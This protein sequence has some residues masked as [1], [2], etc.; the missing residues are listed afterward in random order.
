VEPSA[1]S[2]GQVIPFKLSGN[3]ST[4]LT[5][6][7]IGAHAD[8]I[9]IGCGG[10]M[11]QLLAAHR[12][13]RVVWVVLAAT[14]ERAT[15]ARLSARRFLRHPRAHQIIVQDFRDGFLPY[16]AGPV[17]E[18]FET[19]KR[20]SPDVIFTHHRDDRHQDHR[21]ASELTWNTFRDH[22]VLEYE[23]PKY[24]GGLGTPNVYVPLATAIQRRKIRLLMSVFASQR[25]KSWFT[26]TTFA[27]LM[28]L[29]G[30]EC[31]APDG[32]AEG[33]HGHKIVVSV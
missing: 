11:L 17:K 6:L 14:G 28:R 16:S 24:D 22:C 31:A 9:E 33:F 5:V 25:S 32:F 27:A 20:V 23:I 10:T 29:R 7:C 4:P 1:A 15:E 8:D 21:L 19:L 2:D 30:V 12:R 3:A 13:I 18:F 26:E